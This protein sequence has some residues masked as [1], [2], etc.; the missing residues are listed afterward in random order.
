MRIR[1]NESLNNMKRVIV[2]VFALLMMKMSFAQTQLEL[3]K[4]AQDDFSKAD[5][6]LNIV[7]KK[8]STDTRMIL[9]L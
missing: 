4:K 3:N 6:E 5:N 8:I 1:S 7:F 2:F 9:C